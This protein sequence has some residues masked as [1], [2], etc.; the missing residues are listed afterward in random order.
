MTNKILYTAS[1]ETHF[2]SFHL[3]YLK[4]FKEL[5][6]EVHVAFNGDTLLPYA[7]KVWSIPFERSPFNWKNVSA[8]KKLKRII[9][10]N[11]YA[12]IH[13]HTPT[14]SVLTRLVSIGARKKGS[15][16]MYSAH[17]FHFYKGSSLKNWLIFFPIE[18]ILANITDCLI[19][20]NTEDYDILMSKKF[21]IKDKYKTNGLGI[22]SKRINLD[23]YPKPEVIKKEFNLENQDFI[24][25]Y[26]AEFNPGKRHEFILN[27]LPL[28]IKHAPNI[29]ILFAG[30]GKL[31]ENMKLKAQDLGV[32]NNVRFLGFRKDIGRFIKIADL[33]IS[34]SNREGFGI[35]VAEIL[36]NEIP[37]VVT[38]IRGHT[39][40]VVDGVNGFLFEVDN[41]DQFITKI[42]LLIQD[43]KLRK[44][45]GERGKET[46][47]KFQIENTLEE[48]KTIY[49]KY[50]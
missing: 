23:S 9:D 12:L 46:M 41:K 16:V 42:N 37:V 11:E 36:S 25:L 29:K 40:V 45:M 32:D 47:R 3:P 44:K 30:G 24:I 1:T 14:A 22:N 33:G 28:L 50:L 21:P 39:E 20:T 15:K 48:M 8:Y 17:G 5:G 43:E 13:C 4:L 27:S 7:D 18:W 38:N 2:R 49:K 35:G 31:V 19:V 6:Y 10:K 34:A 26:I